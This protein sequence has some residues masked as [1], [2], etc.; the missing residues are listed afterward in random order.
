MT[1]T[2]VFG[3]FSDLGTDYCEI[4]ISLQLI[5]PFLLVST[6]LHRSER[7][8]IANNSLIADLNLMDIRG[9]FHMHTV[10]PS[11]LSR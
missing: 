11:I 2:Q 3:L 8:I 10:L 4:V 7:L 6:L 5:V 1:G 9:T